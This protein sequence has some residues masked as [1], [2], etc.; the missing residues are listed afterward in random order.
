MIGNRERASHLW[1]EQPIDFTLDQAIMQ[2]SNDVV[3]DLARLH[4]P[5]DVERDVDELRLADDRRRPCQGAIELTN[6]L[7][8]ER[9]LADAAITRHE[10]RSDLREEDSLGERFH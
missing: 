5:R 8:D 1:I 3:H 10:E 2:S 7:I 6:D 9:R 4:R